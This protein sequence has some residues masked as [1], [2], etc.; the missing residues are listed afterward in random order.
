MTPGIL[1]F[2]PGLMLNRDCGAFLCPRGVIIIDSKFFL[3]LPL[4][5]DLAHKLVLS[6]LFEGTRLALIVLVVISPAPCLIG[7]DKPPIHEFL[8]FEDPVTVVLYI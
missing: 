5:G 6:D 4:K 7:P 3:I 8:T 1:L 2:S